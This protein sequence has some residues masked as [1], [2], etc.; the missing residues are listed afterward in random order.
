VARPIVLALAL[1]LVAAPSAQAAFGFRLDRRLLS[2]EKPAEE[3]LVGLA[4]GQ[5]GVSWSAVSV[6][7]GRQRM[8]LRKYSSRPSL[9]ADIPLSDDILF[10]PDLAMAPDGSLYVV[11]G[12]ARVEKFTPRGRR[13][14]GWRLRG[15]TPGVADE[16]AVDGRGRIIVGTDDAVLRFRPDGRLDRRLATLGERDIVTDVAAS[17][18]GR[19]AVL[20]HDLDDRPTLLAFGPDGRPAT[21]QPVPLT[22]RDPS[23]I[24]LVRERIVVRHRVGARAGLSVLSPGG[25]RLGGTPSR[26]RTT[27]SVANDVIAAGPR[28]VLHAADGSQYK[29]LLLVDR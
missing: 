25:E 29:I 21:A 7:R 5:D 23:F 9:L 18:R 6:R 14:A 12:S 20:V 1:L 3:D 16:I 27:F 15:L 28:G 2:V 10:E 22:V 24:A 4:A 11:Q 13:V 8:R 19:V 17:G 26:G